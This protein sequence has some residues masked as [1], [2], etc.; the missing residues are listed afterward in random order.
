MGLVKC[1]K[2]NFRGGDKE[3]IETA[4]RVIEPV[5][6]PIACQVDSRALR[7]ADE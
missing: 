6:D 4:W 7:R 5:S 3:D 2:E 1:S